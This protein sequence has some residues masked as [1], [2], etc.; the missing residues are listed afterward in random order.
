MFIKLVS[1]RGLSSSLSF[2]LPNPNMYSFRPTIFFNVCFFILFGL[3]T[4]CLNAQNRI[5][6]GVPEQV[7][8][9]ISSKIDSINKLASKSMISNP[10]FAID[11]ATK[12]SVLAEEFNYREG[13][14]EAHENLGKAY[15]IVGEDLK[16]YKSYLLGYQIRLRLGD[17]EE[18]EIAYQNMGGFLLSRLD[19]ETIQ[20]QIEKEILRWEEQPQ[21][22]ARLF[23]LLGTNHQYNGQKDSAIHYLRKA[24]SFEKK[25]RI[26]PLAEYHSQLGILFF[27][28]GKPDSTEKHFLTAIQYFQTSGHLTK[29]A[30][31][32]NHLG[33][34]YLDHEKPQLALDSCFFP[35]LDILDDSEFKNLSYMVAGNISAAYDKLGQPDSALKYLRLC[36]SGESASDQRSINLMDIIH[37]MEMDRQEQEKALLQSEASRK[38]ITLMAVALIAALLLTLA[39]IIW[40]SGRRRLRTERSLAEERQALNAQRILELVQEQELRSLDALLE[41]QEKERQRIASD[42]HDRLGG[43]MAT[44]KLHFNALERDIR[45]E[46]TLAF[47]KADHLID[48]TCSEIRKISHDLAEGQLAAFGLTTAVRDLADSIS[49]AGTLQVKVYDQNMNQR[50][51]LALERDLY[52]II[53]ESLTNVIKHAR[54][55]E[56]TVQLIRHE[57]HLNLMVEDNGIGIKTHP[58]PDKPGQISRQR[59]STGFGL[60]S[61]KGRVKALGGELHIDSRPKTGT[62]ILID[63]PIAKSGPD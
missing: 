50:L 31:P 51:P 19:S 56:V 28:Q 7:A 59:S 11:Q 9:S 47:Q 21:K 23:F 55:S 14:A 34:I 49:G 32:L 15:E 24:I 30:Q 45:P 44:V 38:N 3:A 60:R 26:Y 63:I 52:K 42:L 33:I 27:D 18:T 5:N 8:P 16:S 20:T 58:S 43:L 2:L 6:K 41:G 37:K 22:L 4:L 46:Q 10:P 25:E 35:A 54:A 36:S 13:I 62:T 53:Q 17:D 1:G 39:T 29:S 40:R 48:E 57:D 61:I 12:A